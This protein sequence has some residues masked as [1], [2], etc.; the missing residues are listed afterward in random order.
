MFRNGRLPALAHG[1]FKLYLTGAFFSTLGQQIQFWAVAYQVFQITESSAY[2]GALGAVRVVPLLLFSLI[3]GL[4]ADQ[5]DR[6]AVM[7]AS[8]GLISAVSL[9]LLAMSLT[10]QSSVWLIYAL[11]AIHGVGRAFESPARAAMLPT[12]V[13]REVLPNALGLGGIVW[14]L[15]DVLGPTITGYVIGATGSVTGSYALGLTGGLLSILL[16]FGL[17]KTPPANRTGPKSLAEVRELL[18]DGIRFVRNTPVVRNAMWLDFWATFFSSADALLPAFAGTILRLGPQGF[19]LL[20]SSASVGALLGAITMSLRPTPKR[21]GWGVIGAIAA[22]GLFTVGLAFSPNFWMAAICLAGTGYADMVSTVLRQTIRQLAT[23]DAMRGRMSA[24]GNI[25]QISG[26]QL[27]DF[28]AGLLA[29][30]F[31]ERASIAIGGGACLLLV[32]VWRDSPLSRYRHQSE[33]SSATS[34]Q[35]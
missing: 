15:G 24:I 31:G 6:R 19:G 26:P 5:V 8:K 22:Y 3:G 20:A 29:S 28:E 27:G 14:R 13:P 25:F 4:V 32:L 7:I 2:V 18:I 21:Q 33:S 12:L 23:P 30:A 35:K 1:P 34:E 17:P 11:V 10:G 16:F 9:G